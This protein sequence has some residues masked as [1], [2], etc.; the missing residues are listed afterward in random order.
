MSLASQRH[1]LLQLAQ[2]GSSGEKTGWGVTIAV[3]TI[4][5]WGRE[6]RERYEDS[7]KKVIILIPSEIPLNT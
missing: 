4:F 6:V 1:C 5:I 3:L 2:T 7:T